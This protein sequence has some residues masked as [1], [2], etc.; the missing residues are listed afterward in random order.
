MK[1]PTR[2][3]FNY[4][5]TFAATFRFFNKSLEEERLDRLK[6]REYSSRFVLCC[7]VNSLLV[8]VE[9]ARSGYGHYSIKV[10]T[11]LSFAL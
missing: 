4:V 11:V 10:F 8:F 6:Y 2:P 7:F 1:F 5:Y 9:T 3:P